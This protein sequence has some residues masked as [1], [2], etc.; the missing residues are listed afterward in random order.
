VLGWGAG[1][2]V[3]EAWN[4]RQG[5]NDGDRAAIETAL[6]RGGE[7]WASG[8]VASLD[9]LLSPTFTQTDIHGK[10]QDR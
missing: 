8:D 6:I 4:A 2:S 3:P 5:G 1:G 10:F 7:A 9:K